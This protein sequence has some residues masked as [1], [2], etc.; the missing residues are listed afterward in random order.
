VSSLQ[1]LATMLGSTGV[2]ESFGNV[3]HAIVDAT[4]LKDVT[5]RFVLGNVPEAALDGFAAAV[6]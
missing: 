4:P 1:T 6:R 2:F 5:E 3:A